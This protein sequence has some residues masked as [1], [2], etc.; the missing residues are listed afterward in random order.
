[1]GKA[2]SDSLLGKAQ[3]EARLRGL[4]PTDGHGHGFNCFVDGYKAG[5]TEAQREVRAPKMRACG[6]AHYAYC[7]S[8][9]ALAALGLVVE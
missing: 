6:T 4:A 7:P 8:E 1:M 3:A 9:E 2:M 5:Y